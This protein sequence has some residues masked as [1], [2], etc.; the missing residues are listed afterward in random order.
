MYK[1][2][3]MDGCLIR[4]FARCGSFRR[5][6]KGRVGRV[7]FGAAVTMWLVGQGIGAL[8]V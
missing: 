6:F 8:L 2:D 5:L 7:F 3:G 1:V 4:P